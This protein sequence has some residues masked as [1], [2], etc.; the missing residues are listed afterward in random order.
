MQ[1]ALEYIKLG[2]QLGAFIA[3]IV[4]LYFQYRK[5]R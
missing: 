3:S 5:K 4:G 1:M 2:I